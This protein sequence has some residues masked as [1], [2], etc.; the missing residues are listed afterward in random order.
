MIRRIETFG[1]GGEQYTV[2]EAARY[3]GFRTTFP[4]VT[5]ILHGEDGAFPC[6]KSYGVYVEGTPSVW[7]TLN[8]AYVQ[9]IEHFELEAAEE[10][11]KKD[12]EDLPF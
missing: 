9:S 5:K 7:R 11:D 1:E 2:G 3:G 8:P 12:D 6:G 10:K 4:K